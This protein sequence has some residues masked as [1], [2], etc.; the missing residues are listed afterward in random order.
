MVLVVWFVQVWPTC[1]KR[2]G[3]SKSV[4]SL[5]ET[6]FVQVPH[7]LAEEV[8]RQR[9]SPTGVAAGGEVN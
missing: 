2:P 3:L 4:H 1:S 5:E 7:W 9:P 6:G 8:H